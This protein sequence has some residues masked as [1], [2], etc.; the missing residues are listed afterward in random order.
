MARG[1]SFKVGHIPIQRNKGIEYLQI[2]KENHYNWKG[3]FT[4]LYNAIRGCAVYNLWRKA[5]FHKDKFQCQDCGNIG[6]RLEAHHIYPFAKLLEDN[7]IISLGQA[8]RIEELWNI[9]NGITLC[10]RCHKTSRRNN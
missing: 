2:S 8:I 1:K 10:Q 9:N 5:V 4:P 3:G 6:G 7:E